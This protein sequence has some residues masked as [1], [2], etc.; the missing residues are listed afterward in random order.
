MVVFPN[1][2]INIGLY[3]TGKR[4][5]GYHN[6]SSCFYPIP[7]CDILEIVES[8]SLTFHSSGIEIPGNGE[9]NLCL[10]AYHL[11]KKDHDLPPVS[12]HLHKIIPIG[13]GLGGGSSDGTFT[14]KALNE[15]F[16]LNLTISQL[17]EYALSLG[18]DC[19]FFIQ[20]QPVIV[21]G[22]GEIF[23]RTDLSLKGKF[24]VLVNPLIH[25]STGEAFS[26]IGVYSKEPELESMLQN[27]FEKWKD[28]VKNDFEVSVFGR[29]PEIG[30]IKGTFYSKGAI[31]ASMTG[32]GATVF[33]VFDNPVDV[34]G[35]FPDNY[36]TW[37]REI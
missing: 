3:I 23:K 8:G 24:V 31:Y 16:Q 37:V 11:L 1:A 4:E 29:Y 15:I 26:G 35:W 21:S 33:G 9:V 7:W 5:D 36:I 34:N 19:P 25:I 22:R 18:S 17:E 27:P 14:L 6:L 10:K 28:Q 20:N 13:A 2:K 12:V 32:S 30:E